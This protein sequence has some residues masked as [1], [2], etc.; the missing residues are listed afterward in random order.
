MTKRFLLIASVLLLVACSK[1]NVL[2]FKELPN[3]GWIQNEWA[4]FNYTHRLPQKAYAIDLI[5]RH[6]DSYPFAN[7]HVISQWES[8]KGVKETD[9][10]SFVLANPDG[11]WKGK[12]LYVKEH[13]L[14]Y[15]E[16]F[17]LNEPGNYKFRVRPA[18]RE[19]EQLVADKILVGIHQI[20][21]KLTPLS[22]E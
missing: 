9:T 1:K 2:L 17:M 18:V 4:E 19:T 8:P 11:R 22:N 10:L 14:P 6:D 13:T 15:L 16:N 12:G 21:I 3:E 7:I 5:L 20:G